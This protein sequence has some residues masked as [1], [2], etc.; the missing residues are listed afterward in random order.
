MSYDP[1]VLQSNRNIK[2]F[3]WEKMR[4][5]GA[6]K[7][8]KVADPGQ[9]KLLVSGYVG[10]WQSLA[11]KTPAEMRRIL[12]LRDQDLVTG[13]I[14]YRLHQVPDLNDFEV[15][16][17]STLPDGLPLPAGHRHDGGGY[18]AGEGVLQYK[19]LNP[20]P[21]SVVCHLAPGQPLTLKLFQTGK[22]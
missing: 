20:V 11:G 3:H 19:L 4:A 16:G 18:P 12:G 22:A 2:R 6:S 14:I 8:V 1:R 17:Y 5:A 10:F 21:A 7:L 15:R 9:L 13:A